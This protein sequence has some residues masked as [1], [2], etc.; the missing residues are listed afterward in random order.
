MALNRALQLGQVVL[1]SAD[2][3]AKVLAVQQAHAVLLSGE[4]F[5][6][7][8]SAAIRLL[9]GE[10]LRPDA[11]NLVPAREMPGHKQLG[12]PLNLYLVRPSASVKATSA[13]ASS[14]SP[15]SSIYISD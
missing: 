2:P 7:V 5:G 12:V 15:A 8:D 9:P 4:P 14:S 3:A 11:P 1:R 10:P 6:S 13:A